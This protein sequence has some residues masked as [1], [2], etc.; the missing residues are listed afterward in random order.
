MKVRELPLFRRRVGAAIREQRVALAL[1]QTA[2]ANCLDC[3]PDYV[4]KV[5][6]GEQNITLDT[7]DRFLNALI[8]ASRVVPGD[9]SLSPASRF[10]SIGLLQVFA[11]DFGITHQLNAHPVITHFTSKS[12]SSN[13]RGKA[14]EKA[15]DWVR[16]PINHSERQILGAC[17][18]AP[19]ST[20]ELLKTLGYTTRTGNFKRGLKH[21]LEMQLLELSMPDHPRSKTQKYILTAKGRTWLVASRI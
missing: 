8:G 16:E 13:D 9:P 5:E 17:R 1:S 3:N 21:L 10:S 18:T 14:H 19:R 11:S 12:G 15:H 7:L 2:L 6:R 20:P 4:G